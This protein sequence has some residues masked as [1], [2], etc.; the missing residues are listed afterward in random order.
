MLRAHLRRYGALDRATLNVRKQA[1][2]TNFDCA[3]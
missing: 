3:A 1:R 2:P